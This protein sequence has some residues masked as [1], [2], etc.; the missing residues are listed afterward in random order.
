MATAVIISNMGGPDSLETVE[1][2]LYNIFKDPDI[3]D[4]PLP[5]RW[6]E[7]F[8]RWL[9]K[10]RGPESRE[11]YE[12]IG[13]K[14]PLTR[15]TEK[16]ATGLQDLLNAEDIDHFDVFP[17]MRYWHPFIEDVWTD[18]VSRKYDRIVILTLYPFYSTTTTG[19]LEQ[20][21]KR[22]NA[23]G[24]VADQNL[25][26]ISRF[27]SHPTFI[28]A[29]AEQINRAIN[30][31]R[32]YFDGRNVELMFSAHSIPMRRIR[33][34]DPYQ[35]EVEEAVNLLKPHLPDNVN[36]H[37]C[38]QSKLGPIKWLE[39]QTDQT[40][41][42]L[43]EKGIKHLMVYPLGFVADNSETVYEIGM[44]YK[45]QALSNG[46]EWFYRIPSLNIEKRFIQALAEKVIEAY[47]QKFL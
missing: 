43:A 4:I 7:K 11:I 44:L 34:G 22:L 36:I 9:A 20:L 42:A 23:D 37:L 17:A 28:Q 21:I 45:E 39:P 47:K 1:P 6:R 2:Y 46:M 26:M 3:I 8:V 25:L 40:I 10:K 35:D 33:K 41:D 24:T 30:K 15:I 18:V 19:S 32:Q 27:G 31:N 5:E 38:Y 16:Q 14:T 29:M 13:G 12:K